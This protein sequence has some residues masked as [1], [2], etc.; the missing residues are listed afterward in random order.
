[1]AKLS[2]AAGIEQA[3]KHLERDEAVQALRILEQVSWTDL[4]WPE[5]WQ[6]RAEAFL[7]L[8]EFRHAASSAR[9]GLTDAPDHLPLLR[10]Y[11]RAVLKLGQ[12]DR[13]RDTLDQ[14]LRLYPQDPELQGLARELEQRGKAPP[15]S[16]RSPAGSKPSPSPKSRP[17]EWAILGLLFLGV[18]AIFLW[19]WQNLKP[20]GF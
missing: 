8:G 2:A 6:V 18:G 11:V 1:M 3:R 20:N 17:E 7:M 15:A 10:L 4:H 19:L 14:A 5:Y 16:V 12:L 13:A 9:E